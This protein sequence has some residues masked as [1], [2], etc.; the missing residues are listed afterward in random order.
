MGLWNNPPYY[1]TAYGIAV[2]HGFVGSEKK[3]LDSLKG[4]PGTGLT[5]VDTFDSYEDLIERYPSGIPDMDGFCRVGSETDYRLYYWDAEDECWYYIEIIGPQGTP[6]QNGASAYELAVDGGYTGTEQQFNTD[7]A[8][9]KQYAEDAEAAKT[10]AQQEAL[11]AA[12]ERAAADTAKTAA[13]TAAQTAQAGATAAQQSAEAASRSAQTAQL[14]SGSATG[15]KIEAQTAQAA[16][17]TAQ[18]AAE[19]AADR[20]EAAIGDASWIDFGV[21]T[22]T[23]GKIGWLYMIES[24][25]YEGPDFSMNDDQGEHQ[26]WL[27]VSYT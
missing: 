13:Q 16:A 10:L 8:G 27:E 5:I 18:A 4:E 7:L 3:W 21:E 22:E 19:L 25:H 23:A 26:G 24:E 15:A 6:G 9:F 17:E 14:A 11:A 12:S 1:I 2:K 20:A